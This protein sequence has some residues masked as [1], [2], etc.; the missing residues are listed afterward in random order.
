MRLPDMQ[1]EGENDMIKCRTCAAYRPAPNQKTGFCFLQPPT[2]V[3]VGMQ[4]DTLGRPQPVT[5]MLRPSVGPDE[6]CA[7]WQGQPAATAPAPEP[8]PVTSEPRHPGSDTFNGRLVP[9]SVPAEAAEAA[10]PARHHRPVKTTGEWHCADCG[11]NGNALEMTF[12]PGK[13]DA[14]TPA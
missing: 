13:P 9:R 14:E 5:T 8:A 11:C 12:C 4:Q 6:F 10:E 3:M 7:M 1:T 2:P